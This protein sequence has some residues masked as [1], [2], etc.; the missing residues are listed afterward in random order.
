MLVWAEAVSLAAY[1]WAEA[2]ERGRAH[3]L[4]GHRRTLSHGRL[5]QLEVQAVPLAEIPQVTLGDNQLEG[6]LLREV[7]RL[8]LWVHCHVCI[9]AIDEDG[10]SLV[11][12]VLVVMAF[13]FVLLVVG[14]ADPKLVVEE[15]NV[16]D[17]AGPAVQVKL[18]S[19]KREL[20]AGVK[21]ESRIVV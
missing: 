7:R 15:A 13:V 14:Q 1:A 19:S 3:A 16:A 9:S 10:V 6:L 18:P 17:L 8:D 2:V 5:T 4:A 11:V 21:G 12:V 20:V